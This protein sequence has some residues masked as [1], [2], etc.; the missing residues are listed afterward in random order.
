MI[1][2]RPLC[3]VLGHSDRTGHHILSQSLEPHAFMPTGI[4]VPHTKSFLLLDAANGYTIVN[5]LISLL[6]FHFLSLK[7]YFIIFIMTNFICILAYGY[8]S[9]EM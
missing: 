8:L 7:F 5:F 6:N 2:F 9:L 4:V 1:P 3:P